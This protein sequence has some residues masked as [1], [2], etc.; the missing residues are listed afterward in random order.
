NYSNRKYP[1]KDIIT[2][3]DLAKYVY[4]IYF[5][6]PAYTR[7]NPGKLLKD[8]KYNV[9]FEINN[10][11]QDYNKYLLAYKIY[12]SVALLN[13]G[14]ITIGDDDFEKVNFIHHLVYVSISLLNKNRNYTFDSLRQI[15]LEDINA[16]LINDAYNIIIQAITEND[17]VASQVLKTIKEQKFNSFINKKLDEIINN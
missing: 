6:D 1:K 5:K 7:N 8:D 11:N 12:D 4:T 9:I 17:I 13:K 3:F 2:L 15:K 16:E 10:S 14:K